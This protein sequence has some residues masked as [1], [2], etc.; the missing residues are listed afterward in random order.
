MKTLS[1]MI[2]TAVFLSSTAATAASS[3]EKIVTPVVPTKAAAY[4][5]GVNKLSAL[6]NSS[7]SQ[8]RRSL[9]TPFG[10]IEPGSLRLK[11]G[12]YV[13]VQERADASGRIGYVAIVNIDVDFERHDSDK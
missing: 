7:P 2:A 11:E 13:T 6:K 12:G 9:S 10:E 1:A 5:Q 4:Q 8:L 3:H